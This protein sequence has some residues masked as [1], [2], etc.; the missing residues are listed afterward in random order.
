MERQNLQSELQKLFLPNVLI[1]SRPQPWPSPQN[2]FDPAALD[3]SPPE[4]PINTYRRKGKVTG[5]THHLLCPLSTWACFHIPTDLQKKVTDH[6][7]PPTPPPLPG[8]LFASGALPSLTENPMYHRLFF[9]PSSR[10]CSYYCRSCS[11]SW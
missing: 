10:H 7:T 2:T 11:G 3:P 4:I 5:V 8:L 6:P 9:S 1:P